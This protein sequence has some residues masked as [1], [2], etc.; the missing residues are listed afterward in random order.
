MKAIKNGEVMSILM[1]V[2]RNML[3]CLCT[4]AVHLI[5]ELMLEK[6][7]CIDTLDNILCNML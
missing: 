1:K 2:T 5:M 7:Q 6:L 3:K 4:E